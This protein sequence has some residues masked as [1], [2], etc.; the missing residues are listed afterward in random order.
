[1]AVLF[2]LCYEKVMESVLAYV[3]V[4]VARAMDGAIE[5]AALEKQVCEVDDEAGMAMVEERLARLPPQGVLW[6]FVSL[7]VRAALRNDDDLFHRVSK[8]MPLHDLLMN[9]S[10]YVSGESASAPDLRADVRAAALRLFSALGSVVE[11]RGARVEPLCT[12]VERGMEDLARWLFTENEDLAL[13]PSYRFAR[14]DGT[15]GEIK[16]SIQQTLALQFFA[17]LATFGSLVMEQCERSLKRKR[18]TEE[19]EAAAAVTA[20]SPEKPQPKRVCIACHG[21]GAAMTLETSA[22]AVDDQPEN[23]GDEENRYCLKCVVPCA[24]CQKEGAPFCYWKKGSGALS[25]HYCDAKCE[26]DGKLLCSDC[27]EYNMEKCEKA[28][29]CCCDNCTEAAL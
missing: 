2:I 9:T 18:E 8:R 21:C 22:V 11:V 14:G 24:Q 27:V 16:D 26:F 17:R 13:N 28:A 12:L 23:D 20:T 29:T 15:C 1:L 7:F 19:A 6:L 5:L 4:D 10:E 3:T 25:G